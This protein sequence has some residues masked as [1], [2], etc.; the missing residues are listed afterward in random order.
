MKALKRGSQPEKD[1][2][3]SYYPIYGPDGQ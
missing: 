2:L 3:I 1:L